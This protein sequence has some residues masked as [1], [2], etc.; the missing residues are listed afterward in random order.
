MFFLPSNAT[1]PEPGNGT[2]LKTN[3]LGAV[4][5]I[6]FVRHGEHA[7]LNETDTP[8][9][10]DIG[11]ARAVMLPRYLSRPD[12][13]K[14]VVSF[15]FLR[16]FLFFF[17]PRKGDKKKTQNPNLKKTSPS[18]AL[19]DGCVRDERR[20]EGRRSPHS[21]AHEHRDTIRRL[22]EDCARKV[23]PQVW[24]A[25]SGRRSGKYAL[26]RARAG[27]FEHLASLGGARDDSL[28]GR[29]NYGLEQRFPRRRNAGDVQGERVEE[30][31]G[32]RGSEREGERKRERRKRVFF[33]KI[34]R[35]LT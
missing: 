23:Y 29:A 6:V 13:P 35:A 2:S 9:M 15:F 3:P 31:R 14:G 12:A 19:P 5:Q 25:H 4:K 1:I 28:D 10:S 21:Q 8:C 27:H 32:R 17:F 16:V 30:K 22:E 7:F 26:G 20:H 24:S 33:I 11:M 18:P 34:F